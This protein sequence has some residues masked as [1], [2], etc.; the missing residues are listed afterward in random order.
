MRMVQQLREKNQYNR[1]AMQGISDRDQTYD[2][3]SGENMVSTFK[4]RLALACVLFMVFCMMYTK[5]E[6][7]LG[8]DASEV[9]SAVRE[10]YTAN[11]FDFVEEIPYT[12]HDV[13][14]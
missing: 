9:M 6:R 5:G 7:F 2:Y 10:D 8:V 13:T 12:L 4:L 1:G 14:P 3:G 11:L